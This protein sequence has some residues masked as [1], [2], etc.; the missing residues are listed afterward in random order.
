ME[1]DPEWRRIDAAAFELSDG[2]QIYAALPRVPA[3]KPSWKGWWPSLLGVLEGGWTNAFADRPSTT[4]KVS[5]NKAGAIRAL[6]EI[7]GDYTNLPLAYP[8][9]LILG[10]DLLPLP[11]EAMKLVLEAAWLADPD[12]ARRDWIETGYGLLSIFQEGVGLEPIKATFR[13][14]QPPGEDVS[15]LDGFMA[16]L[17]ASAGEHLLLHRE[18]TEF[19]KRHGQ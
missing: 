14:D 15:E 1:R 19:K 6:W 11:K 2:G 10:A 8:G 12:P 3:T 9:T 5:L 7:L 17:N 18:F 16:L 4:Q 13:V